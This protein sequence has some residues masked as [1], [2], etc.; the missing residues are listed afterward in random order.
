M[1]VFFCCSEFL[2]SIWQSLLLLAWLPVVA[3]VEEQPFPDIPF[4]V[5]SQFIQAAFDPTITLSTV[6][7]L[8]LTMTENVSLLSL[9]G[10]QQIAIY[11]QEKSSTATG[12][13]KA[14]ARYVLIK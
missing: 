11:Q 6:L 9:H 12:W 4:N 5:F 7:M 10:H 2:Y 8:L 3:A 14:L 1:I 13:I